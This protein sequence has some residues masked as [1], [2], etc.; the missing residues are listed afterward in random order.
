MRHGTKT[1]P[2]GFLSGRILRAQFYD[3]ALSPEEV[4]ASAGTESN[5]ISNKDILAQMSDDE[6]SQK[7][8]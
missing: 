1:A 3:R 6:K 8:D 2:T 5:F 7:N 4:A